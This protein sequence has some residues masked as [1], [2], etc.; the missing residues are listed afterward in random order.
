MESFKASTQYGDWEGTAAADDVGQN[1]V[2]KHLREKGL[3]KPGEFLVAV[4]FYAAEPP[5]VRASM[6]PGDKFETVQ[7]ALATNTGPISVREIDLKLTTE[8]FLGLFKRFS[9][10]LTW[11]GLELGGRDYSATRSQR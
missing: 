2:H 4:S 9:V 11:H 1:S 6:V 3:I 5:L 7:E 10:T 8:E